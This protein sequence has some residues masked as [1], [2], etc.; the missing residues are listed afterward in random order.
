MQAVKGRYLG[1][2]RYY[3]L[4]RGADANLNGD[5]TMVQLLLPATGINDV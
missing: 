3:M 1:V 2:A 5:E 4:G